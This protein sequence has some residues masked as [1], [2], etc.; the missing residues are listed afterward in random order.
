MQ[1]MTFN[2]LTEQMVTLYQQGKFEEALQ[3]IEQH[4]D[5]FPEQAARMVFWRMCLLSL[6]ERSAEVLSAF[7]QG[8]D[9]GLWWHRELFA[10]RSLHG[11]LPALWCR[12]R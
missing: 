12:T 4:S 2:Q 9:S 11:I 5:S 3:L 7:V 1:V 10:D 6:S 8:L